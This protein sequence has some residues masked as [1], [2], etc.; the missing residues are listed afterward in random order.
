MRF[1]PKS[2]ED[3]MTGQL[4]TAGDYPFSIM[5]AEDAVSKAGNEMIKL[6]LVIYADDGRQ[7]HVFDYLLESI[8]HKLRHCAYACGLGT[9][10]ETGTLTAH[11]FVGREGYAKITIQKQ[12]GYDPRN[13]VRDYIIDKEGTPKAAPDTSDSSRAY[14]EASGGR[15]PASGPAPAGGPEFDDD[16]PF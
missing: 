10:Y 1:T 11:D 2:E 16:I 9:Q 12:D 3:V 5:T 7:G 13:T 14:A 8:P 6:K 15:P 4:L